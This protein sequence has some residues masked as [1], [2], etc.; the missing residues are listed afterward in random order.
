MT[1]FG[2]LLVL[3]VCFP[4]LAFQFVF[5]VLT[6]LLLFHS[7]LTDEPIPWV[8]ASDP[9]KFFSWDAETNCL[10]L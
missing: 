4:F 7:L 5:P 2:F 3:R 10:I 9:F 1:W 8:P 6:F